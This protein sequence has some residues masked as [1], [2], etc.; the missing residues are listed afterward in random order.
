[1]SWDKRGQFER[2]TILFPKYYNLNPKI[3]K[4]VVRM[5]K[6]MGGSLFIK[7]KIENSY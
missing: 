6:C 3:K 2:G 5:V 7:E 1:L 4:W